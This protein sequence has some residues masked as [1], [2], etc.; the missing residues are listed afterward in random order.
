MNRVKMK[1]HMLN[2]RPYGE[3]VLAQEMAE[4]DQL[5]CEGR[6]KSSDIYSRVVARCEVPGMMDVRVGQ[7]MGDQ[8][9][10]PNIYSTK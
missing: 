9:R 5:P 10:K 6:G 1:T 8:S 4:G 3:W 2:P 7:A